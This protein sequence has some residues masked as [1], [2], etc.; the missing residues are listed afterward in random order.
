MS[1]YNQ[2]LDSGIGG[3][4]SLEITPR[5]YADLQSSSKWAKLLAIGHFIGVGFMVL[6]ALVMFSVGAS[7]SDQMGMMGGGAFFAFFY[8]IYAGI[9][10]MPGLFLWRFS[11]NTTQALDTND[12]IALQDSLANLSSLFK[13]YGVIMLI[14]LVFM[15]IGLVFG[16]MGGLFAAFA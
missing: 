2:P 13:F 14:S 7:F 8:L 12:Q 11:N 4:G 6:M 5:N 1:D 10:V 3:S 9:M 16:V 15:G